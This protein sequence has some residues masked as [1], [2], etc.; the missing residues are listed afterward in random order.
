MGSLQDGQAT[1]LALGLGHR[2]TLHRGCWPIPV[3]TD[4]D[5]SGHSLTIPR[6]PLMKRALYCKV[7]GHNTPRARGCSGGSGG[8]GEE[9]GKLRKTA[10]VRAWGQCTWGQLTGGREEGDV[11]EGQRK[12]SVQGTLWPEE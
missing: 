9:R 4:R 2:G 7:L 1:H 12:P 10:A 5:S 3:G 11:T 8:P 6:A